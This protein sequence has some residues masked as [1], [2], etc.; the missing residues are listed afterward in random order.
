MAYF[1]GL[2]RESSSSLTS[3]MMATM[4]ANDA[5]LQQRMDT[6]DAKLDRLTQMMERHFGTNPPENSQSPSIQSP[7]PH[8]PPQQSENQPP[9]QHA[10][11]QPPVHS[12]PAP[13]S[14]Q[15][16]AEEVGYFDPEYQQEHGS[17][18]GPV[19][20]AGEY[21]FYKDVY[22]FTDR[23]K[24]LAVQRGEADIKAVIALCLRG[25]A[26]MWYYLELTEL[27]RGLLRDANLDHWYTTLIKR[28]KTRTAVALS[29]LVGQ[30]YTLNDI[31]YASPRAF[32]QHM[33]HLAKSA[34]MHSTHN[35]LTLIWNQ[36]AVNL[37]RDLPEPTP[38]TTVGQFMDQV[39]SKTAIWL[40][41]AQKQQRQRSQP[42]APNCNGNDQ[43]SQRQQ[44]WPRN[45]AQ[46]QK[47]HFVDP[48]EQEE[49]WEYD[50]PSD[51]YHAAPSF[52]PPGHT[53]RHYGNTHD[54]GGGEAQA[55]WASAG[56]DHR[57]THKGCTHY[58]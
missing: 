30:T 21:V 39:D 35:Q 10:P 58:H 51:S 16:R 53:P 3:W 32:I 33:L 48:H 1:P 27:E 46:Q 49:D 2:S 45:P 5:M 6:I 41:M 7:P 56:E 9:Q 8:D 31:L 26:L 55:N 37:R 22:I 29:Q 23:L 36:F 42:A 44:Q 47:A 50:P 19:V 17:L 14:P 24:D 13:P 52:Q 11:L 25:S 15:L 4:S 54:S 40:E 57:C 18:N 43:R 38:S 28:F 12:F 34:E 20:N